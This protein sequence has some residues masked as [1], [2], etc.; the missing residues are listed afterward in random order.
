MANFIQYQYI[1]VLPLS[2]TLFNVQKE[3]IELWAKITNRRIG[4]REERN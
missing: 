3:M 1:Y 4:E 2:I